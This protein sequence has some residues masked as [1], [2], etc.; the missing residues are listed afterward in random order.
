M[1]EYESSLRSGFDMAVAPSVRW[2][3][4]APEHVDTLHEMVAAART[5]PIWP[6][7]TA[8]LPDSVKSYDNRSLAAMFLVYLHAREG[9]EVELDHF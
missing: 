7:F 6:E 4:S 5:M 1:T 3:Y 8:G 9:L 2:P